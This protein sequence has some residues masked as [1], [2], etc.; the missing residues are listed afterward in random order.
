MPAEAAHSKAVA[1]HDF[2]LQKE[3]LRWRLVDSA[4]LGQRKGLV[5]AVL[6]LLAEPGMK[7]VETHCST[8][9]EKNKH[10][11]TRTHTIQPRH[12]S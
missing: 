10:T 3:F 2:L 4:E 12:S 11:H 6:L 7:H 9:A 8:Q 1:F 5:P